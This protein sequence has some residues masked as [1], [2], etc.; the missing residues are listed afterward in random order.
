MSHSST[1][2]T[3]AW[4]ASS[5]TNLTGTPAS[6]N[7]TA[8][9][10]PPPAYGHTNAYLHTF[11]AALKLTLTRFLKFGC[12]F[13]SVRYF[14][15]WLSLETDPKTEY[16]S[17]TVPPIHIIMGGVGVGVGRG[18]VG[19]PQTTAR[20]SAAPDWGKRWS[21]LFRGSGQ[22]EFQLFLSGQNVTS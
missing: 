9:S 13:A 22:E 6:G 20:V 7:A 14:N 15:R 3:G 8:S 10:L 11:T 4:T 19:V 1:S 2:A 12:C 16:R 17:E 5:H 21:P 18:K